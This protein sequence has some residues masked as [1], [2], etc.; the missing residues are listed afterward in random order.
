MHQFNLDDHW[1]VSGDYIAWRWVYPKLR[2]QQKQLNLLTLPEFVVGHLAGN[3]RKILQVT[4]A[5]IVF[6][7]VS[8][9][10]AAQLIAGSKAFGYLFK[11]ASRMGIIL[12][13]GIVLIYSVSGGIRAS[14]WTDVIQSLIIRL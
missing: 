5:I 14:I 7:F 8:L 2:T 4:L 11:Y 12:G 10:A 6:V 13:G 3:K 1:L 9:Y